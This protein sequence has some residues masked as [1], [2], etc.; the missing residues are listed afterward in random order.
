MT[1]TAPGTSSPAATAS[2]APSSSASPPSVPS[3]SASPSALPSALPLPSGVP[4]S[5]ASGTG[6]APSSPAATG[7]GAQTPGG[8]GSG[9][10][11]DAPEPSSS[12]SASPD[13]SGSTAPLAGRE[14][15]AGKARPGRSLSP[16]ELARAEDPVAEDPPEE[17][18]EGIADLVDLPASTPP[19]DA[20][21]DPG[22]R[23]GQALD[24]AAVRRVQEVSLG[25]GI[26]LVGLG[27]GF[28]AFRMR[29]AN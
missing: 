9:P 17:T 24:A 5:G 14:A 28:L 1:A 27:L 29:R 10:G 3:G 11:A 15:G 19:P 13:V 20:F 18:D 4:A 2:A 25:T 12:P 23:S 21:S 8:T 6:P 16:M 22:Q 7:N 26:A